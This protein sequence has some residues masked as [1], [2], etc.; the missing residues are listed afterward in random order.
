[1]TEGVLL[2]RRQDPQRHPRRPRGDGAA[3][4]RC[5][6]GTL[7]APSPTPSSTSGT[8]TPRAYSRRAIRSSRRP[9]HQQGRHRRVHDDLSRLVPGPHGAHPRQGP[10]GLVDRA[11][12]PALLRRLGH[13][14]RL[15]GAPYSLARRARGAQRR[16]RDLRRGPRAGSLARGRR[17]LGRSPSM[18]QP[19]EPRVLVVDDE[20]TS[21]TSSPWPCASRASRSSPRHRRRGDRRRPTSGPT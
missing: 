13:R 7:R 16:R 2:R 6:C 17:R 19:A 1:M 10:P 20:P 14:P 12:D 3:A 18:S 9:G 8:A 11:D 21:S 15:R 5:G 4:S